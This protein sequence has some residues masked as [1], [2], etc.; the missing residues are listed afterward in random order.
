MRVYHPQRTRDEAVDRN[1]DAIAANLAD[2]NGA[3]AVNGDFG[4]AFS[5]PTGSATM[6][7]ESVA[8]F[9]GTTASTI[10]L[11]GAL[12]LGNGLARIVWIINDSAV[13]ITVATGV[14][15]SYSGSTSIAA[16]AKAQFISDG[17]SRW[18]RVV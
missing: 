5:L 3:P 14:G 6:D 18:Y 4:A 7:Q 17:A 13:A 15:D 16:G 10:T 9:K 8:I 1:L 12:S 2:L 11:P